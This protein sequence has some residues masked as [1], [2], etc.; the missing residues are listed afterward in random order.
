M[1]KWK[2][3]DLPYALVEGFQVVGDIPPCGI[4]R[5]IDSNVKGDG[6]ARQNLLG[7]KAEEFIAK[8]EADERLHEHA[9]EILKATFGGN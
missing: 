6:E 3:R 5:K 2:D 7:H 8:L 4:H 9:D 1:L